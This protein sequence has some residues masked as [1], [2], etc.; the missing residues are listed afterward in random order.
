M[1]MLWVNP[2]GDTLTDVW[3]FIRCDQFTYRKFLR[4]FYS[5]ATHIIVLSYP[6]INATIIF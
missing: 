6:T 2:L 5:T 4:H 3:A 1:G